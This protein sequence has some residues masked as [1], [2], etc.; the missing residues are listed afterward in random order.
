MQ[1]PVASKRAVSLATAYDGL[2]QAHA[3]WNPARSFGMIFAPDSCFLRYRRCRGVAE[4]GALPRR[5]WPSFRSVS[6][7]GGWSMSGQDSGN[8]SSL[9]EKANN[10]I[11]PLPLFDAAH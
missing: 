9:I 6:L 11:Y 10:V 2:T 4:E 8:D 1:S 3:Y 7:V 5:R